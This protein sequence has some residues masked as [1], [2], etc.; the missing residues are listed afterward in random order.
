MTERPELRRYDF[1][2]GPQNI[3]EL[4]TLER[5]ALTM[6]CAVSTHRLGWELRLTAGTFN[7][8][9]VCKTENEVLSVSDAWAAE[10]RLKGWG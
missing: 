10:A 1:Y 6:R 9:Q 4:W 3:G 8:S 2:Q 5:D 7:R